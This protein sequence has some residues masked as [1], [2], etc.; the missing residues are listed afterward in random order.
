[1]HLDILVW[2]DGQQYSEGQLRGM[3]ADT[4]F[5]A[6]TRQATAG[7]WSLVAGRVPR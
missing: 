1:V 3:L 6:V 4:G 5:E 7:A 2:T